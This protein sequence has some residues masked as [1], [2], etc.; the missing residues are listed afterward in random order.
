MVIK[1][2]LTPAMQQYVKIKREYPNS[3]LLFRMGDFYETF[4]E[5]AK[6]ASRVLN[7]TLTKRGT[8]NAVPL[9]GIPFHALDSY[10]NKLIKAGKTVT[11][12]EQMEDPKLAKGR[13]VKRDVL[14]TI[15][16]GTVI[17]AEYLDA[18]TNNYIAALYFGKKIGIAFT[19][20]S[21][22]EFKVFE[23]D[24]QN[25]LNDLIKINPAEILLLEGLENKQIGQIKQ[26]LKSTI[27]EQPIIYFNKTFG[28]EEIKE[29]FNIFSLNAF[30]IEN[31]DEIICASG[32]LLNYLKF[33]QKSRLKHIN[34]IQ[35]FNNKD[36]MSLDIHTIKNLE[37]VES[38]S[39]N[40][41][42]TVLSTIDFSKT[43]MGARLLKKNL[44]LPLMQKLEIEKRLNTIDFILTN[45]I[46]VDL[47]SLLLN[48]P[49][50][51]RILSKIMYGNA[52]PRELI[53]LKESIVKGKQIYDY[54]LNFDKLEI[55]LNF[56]DDL[57]SLMNTIEESVVNE[58]PT[59]YKEGGFIKKGFNS[60][61]DEL[62]DL[63][64]NS[65]K[66]LLEIEQ[67]ER[68]K[69]NIKTLKV[70]FNKVFGYFIEIP[71]SQHE[72]VPKDYIRKQ[73]L[74]N[75]ERYITEELKLLEDKI[76]SA[77]E[78][79]K[80]LELEIFDSII[81]ITKSF[82][83]SLDVLAK[84]VAKIDFYNSLAVCA[85]KRNYIK[86]TI[87]ETDLLK[88]INGWHPVVEQIEQEKFIR[89][90]ICMDAEQNNVI[91]LTG[92][93][94]AGKSTYLRQNALV[95]LLAHIGSYVPA[96]SA[97]IPLTDK[98]FTRIGAHD[99]LSLGLSTFMV[100]MIETANIL[101]NSTKKSFII[102]DE[103]GRGTSTYDGLSIAW[104]VLEYIYTKIGA[105]T[106]FAT[107]YHQMTDLEYKYSGIKN[108][109]ISAKEFD[110]NLIFLRKVLPGSIDKSYGIAVAKLAGLPQEVINNALQIE[111]ELENNKIEKKNIERI[112]I[113][114]AQGQKTLLDNSD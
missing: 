87:V 67:K 21:T 112:T 86:P 12:I 91:I 84:S 74:A 100:E 69:T 25:I 22:G 62:I 107:H 31:K 88:I 94:M 108:Y 43:P 28:E 56:S 57:I 110:N 39:G 79:S 58:P 75:N 3:I 64:Y 61:L 36:F 50:L 89:N 70:G 37:L 49:D 97:V 66:I 54:T 90:D 95:I 52:T 101:N 1:M 29:H 2:E 4:F 73:T 35:C 55:R 96:E 60:E 7:I 33:T 93:N 83:E 82:F 53:A 46:T 59:L 16:P 81:N 42:H 63:R 6:E 65:K 106:L 32:C 18:K 19:D 20:I 111:K 40:N 23:T 38:M 76:L 47:E 68:E 113:K 15:T 41:L 104:A 48:Y 92:P 5:D 109:Y 26:V 17:D 13:I 11:I 99:N 14:R 103:V 27:T 24:D 105:K 77:E 10:L 71:K 51:E 102:L 34:K 80:I 78:K 44:L 72:F 98:I 85:V 9:A 45:N 30:D 8:K 114:S